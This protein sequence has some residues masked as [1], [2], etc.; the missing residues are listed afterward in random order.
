MSFTELQLHPA[1]IEAVSAA[2]FTKPTDIQREAIPVALSGR[3]LMASA[4]TG[5]G[6]TAAFVLPALHR[7]MTPSEG[8]GH[9][10]RVLVLTPTRELATQVTDAIR[11]LGQH[12]KL[13]S[14]SIVGG[15]PYPPQQRLLRAPLDL[16][17]ATPGRLLDH[18][19]RG[20]VDFSRLELLVLDEADRMLDMGFVDAVQKIA[21]ETPDSRQT[22]LFSATLEGNIQRIAQR[23]L[24]EPERVQVAGVRVQHA[25][26]TEQVHQAD[27]RRHKDKLLQHILSAD[28]LNQAIIFTATKRAADMLAQDLQDAGHRSAALHGDMSQHHRRRTV[29]RLRRQQIKVLVATDVAARGLDIK[30]LSH[31]VNYDLPTHAEDYVHRIGRT[32]RGGAS[33]T[34]I[35]LVG[36]DDWVKLSRIER[37]TGKQLERSIIDGLEPSRPEPRLGNGRGR[38]GNKRPGGNRRPPRNGGARDTRNS[39]PGGFRGKRPA[40]TQAS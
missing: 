15:V 32:G 6:K 22:L 19:E 21:A 17:V 7:L 26:I 11:Q 37:L 29:E 36:P 23:L 25:S 31:V 2:G 3:D 9:G 18:M 35:S 8:Q 38:P 14:G 34:A 27:D 30:G 40:R 5:T 28:E 4:Q 10:P 12:T 13:R 16:L 20:R 24:K 1:L 33:G 39:K